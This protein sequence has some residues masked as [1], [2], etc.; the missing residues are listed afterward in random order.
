MSQSHTHYKLFKPYGYLSQFQNNQQRRRNKK[1]LGS[2]YDFAPG[3]MAIGR[4]DE[5]S[6]GLL[7]LTTDGK[8]SQEIRSRKIEKEYWVQVDGEITP[9]AI[10][11]LREGVEIGINAKRYTTLPCSAYALQETPHLPPRAKPVRDARHG[12]SS[13]I[14]VTLTE[15]KFRQVRKMTAAVGFPTLRLVRVRIGPYELGQME[16]GQVQRVEL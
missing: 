9:E 10:T 15:G 6:E 5:D 4:L 3:T 16:P 11:R 13:W 8:K 14:S 2:L 1:L 7:L 12:P